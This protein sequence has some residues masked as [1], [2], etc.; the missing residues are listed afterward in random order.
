VTQYKGAPKAVGGIP[1]K[2]AKKEDD[3][4]NYIIKVETGDK[5]F[6]FSDGLPDQIG[7]EDGRKYQAKRIRDMIVENSHKS[8][9]DYYEIFEKDLNEWKGNFKQI[10][11][12]LL[13]GVEF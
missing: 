5:I 10:D 3:F 4:E 6:I 8:M 9:S 7:G 2:R 11:D 13:I 1:V 12:I